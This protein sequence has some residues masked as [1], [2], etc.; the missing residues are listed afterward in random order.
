MKITIEKT[1]RLTFDTAL[2]RKRI[3]KAFK[4]HK[5]KMVKQKL[6]ELMDLIEMSKWE[7]A[8]KE[9]QSKWW[10]GYDEEDECPRFEYIGLI[11]HDSPF[12]NNW[13]SYMDL[14]IAMYQ[15]PNVYKVISKST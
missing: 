2:E 3:D 7:E 6:H 5:D 10:Q 8:L 4:K 11:K 13:F 12:F 9:L 14:V 1:A 15:Y